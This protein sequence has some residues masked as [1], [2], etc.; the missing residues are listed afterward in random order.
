MYLCMRREREK[1]SE[2]SEILFVFHDSSLKRPLKYTSKKTKAWIENDSKISI[3]FHHLGVEKY[4]YW[5]L[6]HYGRW[7]RWVFRESVA[8]TQREFLPSSSSHASNFTLSANRLN[9]WLTSAMRTNFFSSAVYKNGGSP[10]LDL[11]WIRRRNNSCLSSCIMMSVCRWRCRLLAW[12]NKTT[13]VTTYVIALSF[14]LSVIDGLS[15][16]LSF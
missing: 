9:D 6:L 3:N 10:K 4:W 5:R 15:F 13:P 16:S 2:W 14:F 8:E 11:E 12:W 7:R 1:N